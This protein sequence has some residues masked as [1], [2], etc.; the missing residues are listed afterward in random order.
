MHLVEILL[1]LYGNDGAPVPPEEH[2]R[3]RTELTER[4]GGLTA[5]SRAPAEGFWKDG[6]ERTSRDQIVVVEV[7]TPDLD[8]PW[9]RAYRQTLEARLRQ[10]CVV[11][12]ATAIEAL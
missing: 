9:W 11:V 8:R 12:R 4:F 7:M 1:P 2:A 5:F 10:D 6:E 3:V